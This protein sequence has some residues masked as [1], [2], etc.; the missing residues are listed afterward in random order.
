MNQEEWKKYIPDVVGVLEQLSRVRVIFVCNTPYS[1]ILPALFLA[2]GAYVIYS[3]RDCKEVELL[4][5]YCEVFS[6]EEKFSAEVRSTK[7]IA[8]LIAHPKFHINF[9]HS[10]KGNYA[11]LL[12]TLDA[13]VHKFLKLKAIPALGNPPTLTHGLSKKSVFRKLVRDFK[14]PTLHVQIVSRDE[15]KSKGFSH[16]EAVFDG[17]FVCQQAES[18]KE[19]GAWSFRIQ[20]KSDLDRCLEAASKHRLN[21]EKLLLTKFVK[22]DSLSMFGCAVAQGKVLT[23][24]LQTQLIDIPELLSDELPQGRFIGHDWVLR[25]WS[26]ETEKEAVGIVEQ[27][28]SYLYFKGYRGIFGVDFIYDAEVETLYPIECNP[29]LTGALPSAMLYVLHRGLPPLELFHM[30]QLRRI[31]FAFDFNSLNAAYKESITGSH[32]CF[33]VPRPTEMKRDVPIGIYQYAE[34]G[35]VNYVRPGLF[36]WDLKRSNEVLLIDSIFKQGQSLFKAQRAFRLIFPG[37]IAQSSYRLK[38][39]YAKVV[40]QIIQELGFGQ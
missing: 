12:N 1:K 21:V 3:L 17:P 13:S 30:S 29:R 8:N 11:L 39:E 2:R 24:G 7:S 6:F 25:N 36:P 35:E 32:V 28:G 16:Y 31:E 38:P 18:I 5:R 33:H 14:L 19:E 9:L 34:N 22:G 26:E 23:S 27:V 15:L 10:Q 20:N 40:K 4:R 37:S